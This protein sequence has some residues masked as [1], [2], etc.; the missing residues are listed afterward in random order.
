MIGK[1]VVLY[2]GGFV[3]SLQFFPDPRDLNTEPIGIH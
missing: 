2:A 3:W 1:V